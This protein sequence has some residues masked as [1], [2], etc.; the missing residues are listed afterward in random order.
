MTGT[1]LA[2][3]ADIHDT[4]QHARITR[5]L[6]DRGLVT[7]GGIRNRAALLAVARR[8]LTIRPHPDADPD[9][10][11]VI[12]GSTDTFVPGYAA[13]ATAELTPHTDGTSMPDPPH[14]V[15]L[16]CLAPGANGGESYLTDGSRVFGAL[17]EHDPEALRALV[18]PRSACFGAAGGYLG[19]VFED[20]GG[21]RVSVRLRTDE[22]A[23]FSAGATQMLP[24]LRAIIDQHKLSLRL[25]PG[26]GFLLDNS[27][28]LH[29]RRHY[30]GQRVMMRIL[31]DPLPETGICPGFAPSGYPRPIP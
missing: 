24:R 27:R 19:S 17:A 20:A 16:A 23:S 1:F 21:G 7:F 14:L 30:T 8:L 25:R 12:N 31:G 2:H 9:G 11:T 26:E 18:A 29:G 4:G 3:Y 5:Q 28:W 6:R 13:F 15:M 22:L 10:V